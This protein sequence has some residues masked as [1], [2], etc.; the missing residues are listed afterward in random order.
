MAERRPIV[1]IDGD[2]QELPSGD[3]L[4]S[5]GGLQNNYAA[6]SAPTVTDDSGSGYAV[7]SQWVD[8]TKDN[9]YV[10]ADASVGAAIWLQTNGAGGG[11]ENTILNGTVDPTTEGADGDFYINTT[12]S[13][14][15]G[16]KASGTWPA[17]VSLVGPEGSVATMVQTEITATAYST[18]NGDFAGNVIRRMNN[19]SAQTITVEPSMTGG[20]PV[21]FIA[22][23]AGAVS[24]AEGVGVTIHSA[25]GNLTIAD[26][27]GS[28]TLI[29]DAD[30]A[31][32]YYLIG[33]LT[34]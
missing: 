23:G 8:V 31:N 1:L 34:T 20:Q 13:T 2:L 28:A 11:S 5:A 30:T 9:S 7:G 15:F 17:G 6:T 19:V 14:I 24:F 25:G 32:T 21:T 4:P 10:C 26:Q 29:P 12:S 18:V 3:T 22:A 33:N 16:P 27:Y